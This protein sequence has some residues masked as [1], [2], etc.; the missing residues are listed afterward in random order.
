MFNFTDL[1]YCKAEEKKGN[2][3]LHILGKDVSHNGT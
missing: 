2:L 3:R 1:M